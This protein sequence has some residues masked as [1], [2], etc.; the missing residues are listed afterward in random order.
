[1]STAQTAKTLRIGNKSFSRTANVVYDTAVETA[2]DLPAAKT[3]TLS[4]RTNASTGTLTMASGHGITTAAVI[5]LYTL[6]ADGTY[7]IRYGITVGTVATNSVPISGGSGDDLPNLSSAITAMVR[8]S[9][10]A[11]VVG[12]NVT[13]IGVTSPVPAVVVIA[14]SDGTPLKTVVLELANDSYQWSTDDLSDNPL[15]GENVG[16]IIMTHGDSSR[17]QA[18]VCSIAYA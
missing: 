16:K 5:D 1:M 11:V 15:A 14:E 3:G 10:D 4:T 6:L 9:E 18:P 2:P 12:D 17:A 8:H 7:S 13:A